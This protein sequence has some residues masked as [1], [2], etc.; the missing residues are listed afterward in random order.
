MLFY[1]K[2]QEFVMAIRC[3]TSCIQCKKPFS[4]EISEDDLL[5]E[6][7]SGCR[8]DT[9]PSNRAEAFDLISPPTMQDFEDFP[10]L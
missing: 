6:L 5:P 8:I 9:T 4:C 7:C 10:Y 2:T 1:T 3:A